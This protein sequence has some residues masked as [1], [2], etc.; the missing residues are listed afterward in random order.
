[1]DPR[2]RW[3]EGCKGKKKIVCGFREKERWV[4]RHEIWQEDMFPTTYQQI[5]GKH[6]SNE[7]QQ[8]QCM[9]QQAVKTRSNPMVP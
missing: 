5:V 8:K 1:M 3:E 9:C 4:D 7:P 2:V 6:V